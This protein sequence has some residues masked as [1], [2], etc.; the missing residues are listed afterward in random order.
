MFNAERMLVLAV[1]LQVHQAIR[2]TTIMSRVLV[3]NIN[4]MRPGKGLSTARRL[5]ET[6]I[7]ASLGLHPGCIMYAL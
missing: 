5:H 6:R 1:I 3:R 4:A 2:E 7:T